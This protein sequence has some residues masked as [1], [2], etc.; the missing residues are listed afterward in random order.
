MNNVHFKLV[1]PWCKCTLIL[2]HSQNNVTQFYLYTFPDTLMHY[3]WQKVTDICCYFNQLVIAEVL[4]YTHKKNVLR[5][6]QVKLT[7]Y[8]VCHLLSIDNKWPVYYMK[9]IMYWSSQTNP[10][11][12]G[13]CYSL[14]I[15][16]QYHKLSADFIRAI[17]CSTWNEATRL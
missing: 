12:S 3:R 15:I 9:I 17:F 11:V 6:A 13:S 7:G 1:L 2:F 10:Q 4:L 8:S 5:L 16:C 14:I